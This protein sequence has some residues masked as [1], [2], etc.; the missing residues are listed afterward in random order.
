MRGLDPA[1]PVLV[2]VGVADADAEAVELMASAVEAAALDAG[3][4][5]LLA[6]VERIVVPQ[7]TWSY[8]DPGRLVAA[9]IGAEGARS[10]YG[11]LGVTQQ[12][13]INE[14]LRSIAAGE[15]D[16]VVVVGGESRARARRAEIAGHPAPE[17]P[18]FST[19][20][21]VLDREDDF[22]APAEIDAGLVQAVLQYAMIENALGA[23]EGETTT[24][25]AV[26]VAS[27][28]ERFNRVAR[29]NPRAAF[30]GALSA[31]ALRTPSPANRPLAFP[32]NKWHAS[33]WTVDQA[34]AL[35]F[36]SVE[37]A[38]SRGVATDRWV[39]PLVG[40][41]A[42]YPVS[43]SRRPELHRW[44]V[45]AVLGRAAAERIGRP[46]EAVELVELYSCF[47]AAVRVQQRELG[48]PFDGTPTVT[49][50]MA[51]AGGP[52]NNFVYQATATMVPSLR[53]RPEWLG[54]VTT[55]S[56]ML[57]QP[58][59]AVWSATPDGRPPLL[60]DLAAEAA[61]LTRPLEVCAG[62]HGPAT[63]AT[64]T[65]GYRAMETTRTVVLA[66][67]DGRRRCLAW[68]DDAG[69]ARAVTAGELIGT[70]VRIVGNEIQA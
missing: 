4:R 42:T 57:T 48:L 23:A 13:L 21:V 2:G 59:L 12:T 6:A 37:A 25:Q 62:H 53:A 46:L 26:A 16:V 7:G 49:G 56:G 24:S 44:P 67:I 69:L 22:I 50:G 66:D 58:G 15:A 5:S 19:P 38:R 51:F 9:R 41:D 1:T 31:D 35:L 70:E 55:V 14:A 39:F 45:M 60:S 10:Y 8:A 33:Q 68:S 65:V 28:W 43:L 61:V 34:A 40:I 64:C 36:C 30:P 47:P 27:L 54:L 52:F 18:S 11:R 20:D 29:S 17:T 3:A 32:Y 63:V